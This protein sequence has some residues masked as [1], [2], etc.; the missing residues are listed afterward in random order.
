MF[1]PRIPCPLPCDCFIRCRVPAS[2]ASVTSIGDAEEDPRDLGVEPQAVGRIW[3]AVER[4]YASGIHP[5]IQICVRHRGRVLMDRA[6][7]HAQGNG[8]AD[9][10]DADKVLATTVTPFTTFSASKAVTAML[11]HLLDEQNFIRLD[12][13]V[14]EYIP[15]FGVKQKRWI[16]IRHVLTHRAGIPIITPEL[17]D[18]DLLGDPERIVQFLCQAELAWRPGRQLAYHTITGGFILGELVRRICGHDIRRL[19]DAAIRQP[20]RYRWMSYGVE[21]ADI[22][23]VAVN[24]FTGT[25]VLPP[26]STILRRALSA[27]LHDIVRLSNDPRFFR[28]VIPSANI[29]ATANELSRFYQLLLN[30]GE[31]DGVRVFDRRTVRRATTEHSYLE[32]DLTLGLPLRYGIG[33]IL[34]GK[35]LSLYG[36]DTQ[37]AFG[38]LGLTN[39]VS[40]ADPRRDIA[41]AIMTSGKPVLYPQIYYLFE[42][43]RHIGLACSPR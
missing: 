31:L 30:G 34:G 26:A 36:P 20:L 39:I 8:P 19:L 40:W 2:L 12:D 25:P 17:L 33:F 35:W 22:P 41:A 10:R 37:H 27:D 28:G 3:N 9:P 16:T 21:P 29:V 5:A 15:E 43:L 11:I 13:P 23:K 24:Y 6:I 7:G 32:I 14:C 42:V 4:L 1:V 18:L 38:H